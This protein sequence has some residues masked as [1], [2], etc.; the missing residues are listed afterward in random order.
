[1]VLVLYTQASN[2]ALPK[3]NKYDDNGTMGDLSAY[4]T[5]L[6]KENVD[7]SL[8]RMA[9]HGPDG[10]GIWISKQGEVAKKCSMISYAT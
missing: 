10:R 5:T 7:S 3:V 6:K 9:Y 8:D 4:K 1:M 2:R